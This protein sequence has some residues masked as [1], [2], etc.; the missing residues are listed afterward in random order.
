[1]TNHLRENLIVHD[2]LRQVIDHEGKVIEQAYA[3]RAIRI[4]EQ[5]Y[6]NR[7]NLRFVLFV[8]KL[9]TNLHHGAKNL[10]TATAKFYRFQQFW[11]DLHLEEIGRKIISNLV[12]FTDVTLAHTSVNGTI[13]GPKNLIS[14]FFGLEPY[15][16]DI[17]SHLN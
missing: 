4:C 5:P 13:Y 14:L 12:K 10:C 3:D 8:G 7:C 1:M 17:L 11:E 16:L 9:R 2:F 15:A 6:N